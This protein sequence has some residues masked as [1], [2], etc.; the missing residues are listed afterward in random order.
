MLRITEP[1]DKIKKRCVVHIALRAGNIKRRALNLIYSK[2][3]GELARF[4]V[5]SAKI[6]EKNA[7]KREGNYERQLVIYII[8]LVKKLPTVHALRS[9]RAN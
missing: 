6:K 1:A 2:Q 8:I 9:A 7:R 3:L 5:T 4:Y